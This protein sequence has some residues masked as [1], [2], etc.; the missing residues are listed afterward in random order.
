MVFQS[1]DNPALIAL[2]DYKWNAIGVALQIYGKSKIGIEGYIV[3]GWAACSDA[4]SCQNPASV[5]IFPSDF[6]MVMSGISLSGR[7][8]WGTGG[9]YSDNWAYFILAFL[10]FLFNV[11]ICI[12]MIVYLVYNATK[13]GAQ[14]T[15]RRDWFLY[16]LEFITKIENKAYKKIDGRSDPKNYPDVVF[17]SAEPKNVKKYEKETKLF[18]AE[19]S[20]VHIDQSSE[21][22]K[23]RRFLKGR[24]SGGLCNMVR[25][26]DDQYQS[27]KE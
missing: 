12:N 5:G 18:K 27:R 4:A 20:W 13:P 16:R 2:I 21:N 6:F 1:Y 10:F 22:D 25:V 24:I 17:Y 3:Y 7:K 15:W 9:F 26:K 8:G 14:E 11:I 19:M 23:V